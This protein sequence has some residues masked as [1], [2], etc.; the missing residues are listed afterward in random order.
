MSLE[1][2][3]NEV[4]QEVDIRWVAKAQVDTA[5]LETICR[6]WLI[7][8]LLSAKRIKSSRVEETLKRKFAKTTIGGG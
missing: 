5:K 2:I 6:I 4:D 7:S 1:K 8:G 3:S